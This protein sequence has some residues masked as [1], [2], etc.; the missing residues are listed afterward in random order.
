M[1]GD[2]VVWRGLTWMKQAASKAPPGG[3][4]CTGNQRLVNFHHSAGSARVSKSAVIWPWQSQIEFHEHATQIAPESVSATI[5]MRSTTPTRSSTPTVMNR[6]VRQ[7]VH[8]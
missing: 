8:S 4:H 5:L 6:V 3:L 2:T 7:I 1:T